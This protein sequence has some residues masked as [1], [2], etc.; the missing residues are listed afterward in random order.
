VLG[1]VLAGEPHLERRAGEAVDEERR[2]A[3]AAE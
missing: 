1:Q 3:A 2:A